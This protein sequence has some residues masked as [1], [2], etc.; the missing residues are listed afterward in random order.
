MS[1]AAAV[2]SALEARRDAARVHSF[3]ERDVSGEARDQGGKWTAGAGPSHRDLAGILNRHIRPLTPSEIE[4]DEDDEFSTTTQHGGRVEHFDAELDTMAS[5]MGVEGKGVWDVSFGDDDYS[6]QTT[7]KAGS[8]AV[9]VFSRVASAL[10][11]FI[12]RKEPKRFAFSAEGNQ[13]SRVSLYDKV[14][15]LIAHRFGYKLK[16]RPH[17][18]GAE[19]IFRRLKDHE[20]KPEEIVNDHTNF[21]EEFV[22]DWFNSFAETDWSHTPSPRTQNK[23]TNVRTGKVVYSPTNPGGARQGQPAAQPAG[24]YKLDIKP[25]QAIPKKEF[26]QRFGTPKPEKKAPIPGDYEL[27]VPG[28]KK[29]GKGAAD[30]EQVF[31]D[32]RGKVKSLLAGERT[33]EAAQDLLAHLS[34]LTVKQLTAIKQ[35]YGLKASGKKAELVAKISQRMGG[36][37]GKATPKVEAPKVAEK[38]APKS[39]TAPAGK[40]EEDG[41]EEYDQHIGSGKIGQNTINFTPNPS[42]IANGGEKTIMVDA[43]KLDQAWKGDQHYL[44][45]GE[46]GA[47]EKNGGRASFKKFLETGKPVQS[48]RAYLGSDGKLAFEDGRH[49]FAV[50]RD[51]GIDQVAVSVP[52]DQAADMAK[53]FG[54]T[55]KPAPTKRPITKAGVAHTKK[56]LAEGKIKPVEGGPVVKSAASNEMIDKHV[57]L[58]TGAKVHPDE[59]DRIEHDD[60]ASGEFHLKPKGEEKAGAA[61]KKH[62]DDLLAK[63]KGKKLDQSSLDAGMAELAK[64]SSADLKKMWEDRGFLITGGGSKKAILEKIK[65]HVL[66]MMET[67]LNTSF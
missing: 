9:G 24:D 11:E 20:V 10:N 33:P 26:Q 31:Q 45:T 67:A 27:D 14:A 1:I 37:E 46:P 7:G 4:V 42:S 49:R 66:S 59:L 47:S 23:W 22:A 18:Q 57:T 43:K 60:D 44:P 8:A 19:Y 51:A 13:P 28:A 53:K 16:R 65:E 54:A 50:M 56:K 55:A 15:P 30:R 32:V 52:R 61:A 38:P 63:A 62:L 39:K 34:K 17:G 12:K 5:S 35:E 25:G 64:H 48:S 40:P 2:Q 58:P 29:T 36:G 6:H 3:A 21:S 41:T